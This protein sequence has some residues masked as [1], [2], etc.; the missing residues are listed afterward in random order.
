[1]PPLAECLADFEKLELIG[2]GSYGRV[3]RA[4]HKDTNKIVAIKVAYTSEEEG[5]TC[6][7]LREAMLLRHMKHPNVL[8]AHQAFFDRKSC[9]IVMEMMTCDLSQFMISSSVI[10]I[11]NKIGNKLDIKTMKQDWHQKVKAWLFQ[12]LMGMEYCHRQG[13]IHRDLKPQNI[14]IDANTNTVKLADFGM[15]RRT[16]IHGRTWTPHVVTLWYRAPELLLGSKHYGM[17]ID[18]WSI[19]CIWFE[20]LTGTV[21]FRGDS[22]IDQM[23][24]IFQLCGTPNFNV[25]PICLRLPH[26]KLTFPIWEPKSFQSVCQN[27]EELGLDLLQSMLAYDPFKRVSASDAL[28]HSYFDEIRHQYS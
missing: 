4:K 2:R 8:S 9:S 23:Y 15:S 22:E 16:T 14:L 12:I 26:Y 19:A 11:G 10:G 1:M 5:F 27:L 13:L 25:W 7:V 21:L 20:L 28:K 17:A 6:W 24:Q 3:Y 18:I